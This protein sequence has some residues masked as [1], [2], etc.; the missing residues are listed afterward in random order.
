MK[1]HYLIAMLSV[2][3]LTGCTQQGS[4]SRG[5]YLLLDTSGTY[6]AEL[7]KAKQIIHYVLARLRPGDSFAVARI[8]SASF[9]EKDII[10]KVTLDS[11]PSVANTQKRKF[12]S[13]IKR[14]V[15]TVSSSAYTDISGGMLQAVEYL[16]E[17]HAAHKTILIYSDLKEDLPDNYVRDFTL[18]LNGF[19]VIALNV[20]KLRSDN[21][22]PSGYLYRLQQWSE[23]VEEGGGHW[24]VINDLD[25]KESFQLSL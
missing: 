7:Q 3:V 5:V 22:N 2:L 16:N 4:D 1:T 8:D 6:T 10:A 13:L 11:R 14:F 25:R 15:D 24:K 9:S 21:V 12:A 17:I 20:T 23:K 19:S 18:D